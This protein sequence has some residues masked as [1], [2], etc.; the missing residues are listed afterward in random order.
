MGWCWSGPWGAAAPPSTVSD[1]A[2]GS[3][4]LRVYPDRVD[5]GYIPAMSLTRA[6]RAVSATA[7][8]SSV[9][10]AAVMIYYPLALTHRSGPFRAIVTGLA[11]QVPAVL[12]ALILWWRPRIRLGWIL[13]GAGLVTSVSSLVNTAANAQLQLGLERGTPPTEL[14]VLAGW[15]L[16]SNGFFPV[17][18]AWPVLA[19]LSFPDELLQRPA[20][21]V[22][23]TIAGCAV[24]IAVLFALSPTANDPF[25]QVPN[26]WARPGL[27]AYTPAVDVVFA[28]AWLGLLG[29]IVGGTVLQWRYA[30]RGS[31]ELRLQR[32]WLA[33]GAG[34]S[35]V[36]MIT[37]GLGTVLGVIDVRWTDLVIF[38]VQM[39]V[40]ATITVAITRHGLY[41]IERLVNR[42][43]VYVVLTAVLAG[44]YIG[45]SSALGVAL[46]RDRPLVTA[47][48]T[49][50]AAALFLP[51]RRLVQ[52]Q[53]DRR[54]A[55]RTFVA[56]AM[57][58]ELASRMHRDVVSADT[59][60]GVL[61]LALDDQSLA[62]ALR[63]RDHWHS[64]EG[65]VLAAPGDSAPGRV[66]NE[67]HYAGSLV[68]AVERAHTLS[69]RPDLLR[70]VL[71]EASAP[72][73]II[74]SSQELERQLAE[75]RASR[76]RIVHAG[77]EARRQLERDL[78]DGAQQRLVALGIFLRRV[79]GSL[80]DRTR[81]VEPQLEEAV[82]QVSGAI[83]DLRGI[84]AGV[85]P[86]QLQDG[87][88]AALQDVAERSPV[89][90]ELDLPEDRLPPELEDA[91]Y[92]ITC[93][94]ITNALKHGP[95]S[96]VR[97]R[98]V[99]HEGW[100]QLSVSDDG[101]GGARTHPER[102]GVSGMADRARAHGGTLT[103][104]SPVDLGTVVRL[105][106]PLAQ[107]VAEPAAI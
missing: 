64:V 6:V 8:I 26:A 12:G 101:P 20:R 5:R 31:G 81:E 24:L 29:G 102:G 89:K 13:L 107:A 51:V 87:L 18:Y 95:P 42:T 70:R 88:L 100:L 35:A 79:Q 40:T 55:P 38:A 33:F 73:A 32:L 37:C 93:E 28:I 14:S 27:I 59:V 98:G 3:R 83:A 44:A 92:F 84:A 19:A 17:I 49:A 46:G 82:A 11:L 61:R 72:L 77:F 45:L 80:T 74:R 2:L 105:T 57:V 91:A 56:L 62:V 16:L 7:L 9:V 103:V 94:A 69:Y 23:I 63:G 106:L 10:S 30:V 39:A 71:A 67:V 22:M 66:V 76:T 96:Q 86:P 58:K 21:V 65:D 48:A 99:H 85:R 1:D 75:V 53:V 50:G 36:A 97:V 15:S 68:A 78:H 41:G 60:Q 43:I 34:L 4:N 54:L 47:L 25:E 90:V 104:D 52:A